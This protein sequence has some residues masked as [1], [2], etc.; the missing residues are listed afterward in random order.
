MKHCIFAI[1]AATVCAAAFAALPV[2][3]KETPGPDAA[4]VAEIA[5]HLPERPGWTEKYMAPN[6]GRA[7]AYLKAPIPDCSDELYLRFKRDGNR[8]EYQN[9]YGR[10]LEM[11]RHL[12]AMAEKEGGEYLAKTEELL[13]AI[14]AER[15]WV[16]P[17]HDG[18]LGNFKCQSHPDFNACITLQFCS[19][20]LI[21]FE[22]N[23]H[24]IAILINDLTGHGRSRR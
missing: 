11:L 4:R 6:P 24:F 23:G 3:P 9:V 15:S 2:M 17:A 19:H 22:V 10:R 21:I 20:G 12:A 7:R 18:S 8:T 14:C 16:M 5:S 1:G 13:R